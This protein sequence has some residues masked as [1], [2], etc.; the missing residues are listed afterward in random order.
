MQ[1]EKSATFLQENQHTQRK[2]CYIVTLKNDRPTKIGHFQNS[3]SI[4]KFKI[5]LFCS[6]NDFLL[7]KVN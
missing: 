4:L 3:K 6:K 1:D 2:L 5:Q 7:R